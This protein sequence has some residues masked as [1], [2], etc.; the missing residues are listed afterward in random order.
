MGGEPTCIFCLGPRGP[1]VPSYATD[2]IMNFLGSTGEVMASSGISDIIECCY[3]P[4]AISLDSNQNIRLQTGTNAV[5]HMLRA[6]L[7]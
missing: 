3:G 7:R 6:R 1:Q 5:I 2:M 4:A